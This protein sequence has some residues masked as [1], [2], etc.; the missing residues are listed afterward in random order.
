MVLIGRVVRTL[1][2]EALV[3]FGFMQ[4][5]QRLRN[6]GKTWDRAPRRRAKAM[7]GKARMP[8]KEG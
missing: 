3:E 5:W 8:G 4:S 1:D 2:D 6:L 7:G